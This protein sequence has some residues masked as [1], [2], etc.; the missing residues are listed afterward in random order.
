MLRGG[1]SGLRLSHLPRREL[2]PERVHAHVPPA[3][4]LWVAGAPGAHANAG[5]AVPSG[6]MIGRRSRKRALVWRGD[7]EALE[8]YWFGQG[9]QFTR[10]E[11]DNY[12][13]W[14]QH[15]RNEPDGE[16]DDPPAGSDA[17]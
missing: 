5:R 1:L 3:L 13:R 17:T 4:P 11:L 15:R 8:R 10:E 6:A 7:V 12:L 2:G 9:L 14:T 16:W